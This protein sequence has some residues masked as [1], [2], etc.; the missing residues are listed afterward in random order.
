MTVSLPHPLQ[1][2]RPEE[3]GRVSKRLQLGAYADRQRE[4]HGNLK[5]WTPW[6]GLRSFYGDPIARQ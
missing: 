1:P 2:G 3:V 6:G 4:I 5:V